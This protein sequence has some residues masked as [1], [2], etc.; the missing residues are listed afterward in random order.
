MVLRKLETNEHSKTRCLWEKV[1]SEDT[2]EFLDYYYFIKT[3]DNEIYVIEEEEKIVSMLQLNPYT[4]RVEETAFP[5]H[6]IVAVATEEHFRGRGYMRRLLLKAM[7]DMYRRKEPFVF[8][9][10]AAEAIYSP[11][12]FRFVYDQTKG[13]LGEICGEPE[14]ELVEAGLSDAKEMADFFNANFASDY[15]V[16]AVRDEAYY[17]TMIFEQKS[18]NGGVCLM[19]YEGELVGMF[20]YA[21]GGRLEIREPNYLPK[22]REAFLKAAAMLRKPGEGCLLHACEE[23]LARE[24]KPMIMARILHLENFLGA[25][26]AEEGE[27][28]SCSFAVLDT[29]LV[30]NSRVFRVQSEEQTGKLTVKETEDS[31]GILPIAELTSLLFGYR[32]LEEIR[33]S[34]GVILTPHL[35]AELSKIKKLCRVY[36]NEVV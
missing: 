12:D 13:E 10:P 32:T 35:E 18:E 5:C 34:Q 7:E 21:R 30:K 19:R 33:E 24:K 29:I 9:M 31:E 26:K 20:A 15:Q 17:Q 14:V 4:V 6:Y 36:L 2:R 28:I 1:F 16:C 27:E 25:L 22:W 8:L 23:A 3:R 11:Y